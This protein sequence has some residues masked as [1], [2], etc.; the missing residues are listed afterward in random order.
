MR[1]ASGAEAPHRLGVGLAVVIRGLRVVLADERRV[2]EARVIVGGQL[3]SL[4]LTL[5]AVL[6][7][8][9]AV[10]VGTNV[11]FLLFIVFSGVLMACSP[12]VAQRIGAGRDAVETGSFVRGT[13]LFAAVLN[14]P[15]GRS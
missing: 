4:V 6:I 15:S 2:V 5:F 11:W 8:L 13:A 1:R 12:I 9:A 10:A 3:L 7:L 14:P